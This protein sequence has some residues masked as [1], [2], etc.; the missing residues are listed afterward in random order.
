MVLFADA[1]M[2]VVGKE[3]EPFGIIEA[4][5]GQWGVEAAYGTRMR[6]D[7]SKVSIWAHSD[8]VGGAGLDDR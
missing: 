6:N 4:E 1:D 2:P 8:G 7:V 5:V 3:D